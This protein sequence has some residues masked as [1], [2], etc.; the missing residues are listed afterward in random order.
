MNYKV[1]DIF[2]IVDTENWA[3]GIKWETDCALCYKPI[4][5]FHSICPQI[6]LTFKMWCTWKEIHG[7]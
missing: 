2:M 4:N 7:F 3:N 5:L 1:K 6:V